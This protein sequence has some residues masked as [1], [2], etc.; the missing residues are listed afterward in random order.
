METIAL[1]DLAAIIAA[2]LGP[3]LL[4]AVASMRYQH[5]DS[6]K[7]RNLISESDSETRKLISAS[8][9]GTRKLISESETATRKL[10][11]K[12]GDLLDRSHKELSRSLGDARERLARIEGHLRISPPPEQRAEDGDGDARAA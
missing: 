5:V 8:E 9:T 3:M 1:S 12:N 2:V 7:T 6:T 4:F 10:I 11:E